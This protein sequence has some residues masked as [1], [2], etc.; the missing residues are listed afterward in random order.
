MDY[1]N[2][3]HSFNSSRLIN[4]YDELPLWSAPFGMKILEHFPYGKNLK[5]LDTG[6]GT[7][8]PL[9]EI[10]QRLGSSSQVWGLDPW[11]KAFKRIRYKADTYGIKNLNLKEGRLEELPFCDNSL[12][13]VTSNNGINN[14]G[15]PVRGI[16]ECFRV[17]KPG[18]HF[19]FTVN[20]EETMAEYY[21]I[22]RSLMEQRQEQTLL[23]KLNEHI[24]KKRK[25]AEQLKVMAESAGFSDVLLESD[26]FNMKFAGAEA[27]FHHYFIQIYFLPPWIDLVGREKASEYFTLLEKKIDEIAEEEGV[28]N[29]TI[30]YC[31]LKCRK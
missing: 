29:L 8:F 1:L 20:L 31:C 22:L 10:A 2:K 19:I 12:D 23:Q 18:G 25:T 13:V 28:F 15:D 16:V 3:N 6:C 11:K 27:F 26:S 4:S 7:G 21:T 14:C 24:Y 5:V 17:L 30:P 9:L